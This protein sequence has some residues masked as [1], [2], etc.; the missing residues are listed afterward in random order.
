MGAVPRPR[1]IFSPCANPNRPIRTKLIAVR[2]FGGV[3]C[4]SWAADPAVFP[5]D[6][7]TDILAAAAA[8]CDAAALGWG[9][10][11]L[12]E[13]TAEERLVVATEK[14]PTEDPII[15]GLRAVFEAMVMEYKVVTSAERQQVDV[16]PCT[17][18]LARRR[19]RRRVGNGAPYSDDKVAN[20]RY[21]GGR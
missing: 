3:R 17:H 10:K 2:L 4:R 11:T 5:C 20:L 15:L 19:E 8:A 18:S 12:T 13:L 6:L 7:S 9:G 14:G 1:A 16:L 21:S